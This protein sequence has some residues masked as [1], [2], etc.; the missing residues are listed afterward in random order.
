MV[1]VVLFPGNIKLNHTFRVPGVVYR[2]GWVWFPRQLVIIAFNIPQSLREN[3]RSFLF[4][5]AN[6]Q[7][8]F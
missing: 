2:N 6:M 4:D 3:A 7:P 5:D 8:L 1:N